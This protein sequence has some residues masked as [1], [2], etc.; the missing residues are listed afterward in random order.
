MHDVAVRGRDASLKIRAIADAC[1]LPA[2]AAQPATPT[3]ANAQ[4][5]AAGA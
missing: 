5:A 4:K 2:I 1:E 3:A